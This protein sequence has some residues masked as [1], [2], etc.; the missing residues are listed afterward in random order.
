[1]GD[2][3]VVVS[4]TAQPKPKAKPTTTTAAETAGPDDQN[5]GNQGQAEVEGGK[6]QG[7]V[8]GSN[9]TFRGEDANEV[10]DRQNTTGVTGVAV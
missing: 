8:N 4:Q 9:V 5:F 3:N 7:E 6:D 1:M 2:E 10:L